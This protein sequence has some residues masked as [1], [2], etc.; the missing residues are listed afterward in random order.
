M[1][2]KVDVIPE[3][4]AHIARKYK[5][6]SAAA[7]AWKLSDAFVSAVL[8]GRKIPNAVMLDDAEIEA[9]KTPVRYVRKSTKETA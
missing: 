2:T 6:Q 5:T 8:M 9:V 1:K 7:K 3:L 4:R